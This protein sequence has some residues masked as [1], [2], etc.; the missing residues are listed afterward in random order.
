MYPCH[1]HPNTIT[2]YVRKITYLISFNILFN[3]SILITPDIE[4][5][6]EL[7]HLETFM[8]DEFQKGLKCE[9]L[10]EV[11]QYATSII[12]RL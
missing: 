11:V 6:D 3:Y 10:Y 5:T 2:N 1:Y 12:P 9:D 4:L 8:L 7:R